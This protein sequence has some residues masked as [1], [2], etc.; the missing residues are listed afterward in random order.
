MGDGEDI[1]IL[2]LNVQVDGTIFSSDENRG[3]EVFVEIIHNSFEGLAA[4]FLALPIS[5]IGF[6]DNFTR[7]ACD[8]T[9]DE[10]GV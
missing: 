7:F 4:P 1:A 3:E 6:C 5:L 2:L 8:I 9:F 10:D